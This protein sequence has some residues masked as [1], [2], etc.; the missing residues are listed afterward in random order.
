MA[1]YI[2][3]IEYSGTL[4]TGQQ[5]TA[6]ESVSFENDSVVEALEQAAKI[7]RIA[8]TWGENHMMNVSG[9]TLRGRSLQAKGFVGEPIVQV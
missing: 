6:S 5:G 2:L 9:T 8:K 7:L 3:K 4:A 1:A